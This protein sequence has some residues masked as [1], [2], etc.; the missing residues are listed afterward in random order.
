ME[1]D[2]LI[3]EVLEVS[4]E[5]NKIPTRDEFIKRN[6]F[7]YGTRHIYKTHG[8]YRNLLKNAG[9][10]ELPISGELD[11]SCANCHIAFTKQSRDIVKTSNNFC[12][13]SCAA[14]YNNVA[15]AKFIPV[16]RCVNCG[17][18]YV[19]KYRD[20]TRTCSSRCRMEKNMKDTV[21]SSKINHNGANT[22]DKIR[23]NARRY[24]KHIYPKYCM[25]CG[26]NKHYEVCH[27]VDIKDFDRESTVYDVNQA[28][29]IV[30]LCPNC[31]WEFDN[32]GISLS[33]IKSLQRTHK[34]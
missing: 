24:S 19:N 2:N 29:N 8:S 20:I 9:L 17:V 12:S 4:S 27:V 18:E 1:I 5:L 31:H 11:V 14:S 33:S 28:N 16:Q 21:M 7:N 15:R 23:H 6:M 32:N 13:R 30:H 10:K 34:L 3:D 25:N 22:Y 26:Y